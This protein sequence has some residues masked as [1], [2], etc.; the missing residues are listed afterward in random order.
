MCIW[1]SLINGFLRIKGRRN[2]TGQTKCHQ[3][4]GPVYSGS[5]VF[6]PFS[7]KHVNCCLKRLLDIITKS[8]H[9][10]KLRLGHVPISPENVEICHS[11]SYSLNWVDLQI[12]DV[13]NAFWSS[14]H[15]SL[16]EKNCLQ[17]MCMQTSKDVSL[18]T[19]WTRG[20]HFWSTLANKQLVALHFATYSVSMLTVYCLI[21]T[22]FNFLKD[23][24]II[25]YLTMTQWNRRFYSVIFP[26]RDTNKE[27]QKASTVTEHVKGSPE[28]GDDS[29]MTGWTAF[30]G[31]NAKCSMWLQILIKMLFFFSQI[32]CVQR[33]HGEK[34]NNNGFRIIYQLNDTH[35]SMARQLIEN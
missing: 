34:K 16:K 35:C 28:E 21:N 1:F 23:F 33:N 7:T 3:P 12:F 32:T 15:A 18:L 31:T 20:K 22:Y 26:F 19:E 10:H 13:G 14:C 27:K 17:T 25:S 6:S 30:S 2:P 8:Q 11:T 24:K 5:T 4:A 9:H 29:L